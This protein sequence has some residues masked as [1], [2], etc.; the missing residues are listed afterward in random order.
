MRNTRGDRN[1]HWIEA[2]SQTPGCW[3][4][5]TLVAPQTQTLESSTGS[6]LGYPF[7]LLLCVCAWRAR[8][9]SSS[10]SAPDDPKSRAYTGSHIMRRELVRAC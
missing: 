2:H 5:R 10:A 4:S 7:G 1:D 9:I 3:M 6:E 8:T